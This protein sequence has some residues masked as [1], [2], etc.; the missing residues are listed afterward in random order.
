[1]GCKSRDEFNKTNFLLGEPRNIILFVHADEL[2]NHCCIVRLANLAG[3]AAD[4][5][6]SE[7][8]QLTC[9]Q[10]LTP[11]NYLFFNELNS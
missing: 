4:V 7:S 10:V 3:Q 11:A 6:F 1:M 2:A 5:D 8:K 9:L